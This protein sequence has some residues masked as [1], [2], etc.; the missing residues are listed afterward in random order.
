[1][2]GKYDM[3]VPESQS[4]AM[5]DKLASAGVQVE[6]RELPYGHV[7]TNLTYNGSEVAAAVRFFKENLQP[8]QAAV[9]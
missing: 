7:R 4:K 9:N 8:S 3:I 2:H 5:A 1:M 6:F